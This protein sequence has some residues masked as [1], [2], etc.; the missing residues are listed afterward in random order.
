MY[1]TPFKKKISI[2]YL[3]SYL[4]NLS[5]EA[6]KYINS[7]KINILNN[8]GDGTALSKA[9]LHLDKMLCNSLKDLDNNIPVISEERKVLK[10]AFMEEN[11]WLIDPID[12]TDNYISGGKEYTINIALIQNGN[13]T[14]GI[15]AHPPSKKIWFS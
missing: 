11:Y 14:I 15:I 1:V 8:K 4:I 2:N 13:P 10:E 9:D 7:S 12:G 5:K 3:E 6:I